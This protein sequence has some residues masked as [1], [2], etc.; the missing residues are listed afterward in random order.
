MFGEYLSKSG[1]NIALD[2]L[3]KLLNQP[4]ILLLAHFNIFTILF[5]GMNK[6]Q[7]FILDLK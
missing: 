2:E 5:D 4:R 3:R 1:K 6:V 7:K